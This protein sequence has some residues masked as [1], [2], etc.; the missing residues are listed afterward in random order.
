VEV[1]Q[2]EVDPGAVVRVAAELG[3]HDRIDPD[4]V[5]VEGVVTG[6]IDLV[7]AQ[8]AQVHQI[9]NRVVSGRRAGSVV[10]LPAG[11]D[12]GVGGGGG[13]VPVPGAPPV[14]E[15]AAHHG[16]ALGRRRRRVEGV[17]V[18]V[19]EDVAEAGG[20]GPGG[21]RCRRGVR[22]GDD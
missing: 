10:A 2:L 19:G 9:D 17:G 3:T 11:L 8:V 15:E 7:G 20:G 13:E 12:V 18:H 5:R 14:D 22:L 6:M 21:G 16:A 1:A 4:G